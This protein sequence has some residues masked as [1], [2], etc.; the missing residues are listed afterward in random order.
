MGMKNL[1]KKTPKEI[2]E[3][4]RSE[5]LAVNNIPTA[6]KASRGNKFGAY[7][8]YAQQLTAS[9]G[10]N[11]PMPGSGPNTGAA[12]NPM[13]SNPYAAAGGA[14][15]GAYSPANGAP[16]GYPNNN[17][18]YGGN[19][20]PTGYGN[21]AAPNPYANNNNYSPQQS[22]PYAAA[23]ANL[24]GNRSQS[25]APSYRTVDNNTPSPYAQANNQYSNKF[26]GPNSL[27]QAPDS[28]ADSRRNELFN[29]AKPQP[30]A[31]NGQFGTPAE[32]S[33]TT[34][35]RAALFGAAGNANGSS[36][37]PVG[38][39]YASA[40]GAQTKKP[41]EM[42]AEEELMYAPSDLNAS[43]ADNSSTARG[44]GNGYNSY[45]QGDEEANSEDEDVEAI[46]TQMKFTRREDVNLTRSALRAAAMAEESGRNAL[47]MLGAQGE[48]LYD[49]ERNIELSSTQNKIATEKTRELRTLNRSMFTPHVSNPFN[50]KRRLREKEEQIKAE[51]MRQQMVREN[52]RKDEYDSQQRI[53]DGLGANTN[54]NQ[55]SET[56][57]KYSKYNKERQKYMFEADEEDEALE[58]EIDANLDALHSASKRLHKLAISTHDELERQN[59]TINKL[60]DRVDDLDVGIHMNSHTLMNIR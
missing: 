32:N 54:S 8:Q 14:P 9:R 49:T 46:K 25:P 39:A 33:Y 48:Q 24:N 16:G 58:D 35:S 10:S 42:S 36:Q 20:A 23:S 28:E 45:S 41:A 21:S 29:G 59:K 17:G 34:P 56:A 5:I 44:S 38:S 43:I 19:N 13:N 50:S 18:G 22:N 60:G 51:R 57:R 37:P 55:N 47:G 4:E 12:A 30:Q 6:S 3:E 26:N 15:S 27:A 31:P 7:S 11:V 1:F 52:L 2:S 53:M 40:Y